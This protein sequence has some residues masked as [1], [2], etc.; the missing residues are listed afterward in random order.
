MRRPVLIA[1]A[2]A[3]Q[4]PEPSTLDHHPTSNRFTSL[5]SRAAASL[6]V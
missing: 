6:N 3:L 2:F 5:V 4:N 1:R